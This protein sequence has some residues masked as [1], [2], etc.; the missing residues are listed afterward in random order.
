VDISKN[1]EGKPGSLAN[2]D[3]PGT[4]PGVNPSFC[5]QGRET[6]DDLPVRRDP[7]SY[8]FGYNESYARTQEKTS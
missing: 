8:D 5:S 1:E 7:K 6:L 2:P 4:T 3:F